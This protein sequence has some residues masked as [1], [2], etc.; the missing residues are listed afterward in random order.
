VDHVLDWKRFGGRV[1]TE[2]IADI[3]SHERPGKELQ[4]PR[5]RSETRFL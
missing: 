1:C 2:V 5:R 4:N 3:F